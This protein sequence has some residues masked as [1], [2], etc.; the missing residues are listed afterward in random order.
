MQS[1]PLGGFH[2]RSD[3]GRRLAALLWDYSTDDNAVILALPRGGVPVAAEVS[4]TLSKP[5]DVLVVRRLGVPGNEEL[6]M[7]AITSGDVKLLD[8]ELIARQGIRQE[9]VDAAVERETA[10]VVRLLHAYREDRPP[11]DVRGKR[12]ILVDDGIASG[13]SM[14]A[15][16]A[17]LR[18]QQVGSVTVAVPVAQRDAARE[19]RAEADEVVVVLEPDEFHSVAH[20]Y[21]SFPQTG[22]EE[23]RRILAGGSPVAAV[24]V[25]G[26]AQ[27]MFNRSPIQMIRQLARPFIGA[28][29]DYDGLLE[30]IGDAS[31][32]VL[33]AAN[34]GTHEFYRIRADL[35][36][37]L[38]VEKGFNAVVTEADTV[39]SW[40]VNEYV[41]GEPG[42]PDSAAALEGYARFPAWVWCNAD[43]ANFIGWLRHHNAQA[44]AVDRQVG[45]YGL[46]LFGLRRSMA[47]AIEQLAHAGPDAVE[48]ARALFGCV[49][50]FGRDSRHFG[51]SPEV[52]DP[53]R[54]KLVGKL[55]KERLEVF[56]RLPG[57][58]GNPVDDELL[59]LVDG[60]PAETIASYY[61]DLLRGYASAWNLRDERMM[62]ML[63]NLAAALQSHTGSGKVVVWAHNA[64]AGDA[65]ATE[66]AWRGDVSL[67]QLVREGFPGQSRLI[68][69]TTYAGSVTASTGW[70]GPSQRLDLP[71]AAEGSFEKLFH[72]VG[73]AEFWLD[74]TRDHPAVAALKRPR[75]ERAV[76]VVHWGGGESETHAYEACIA[77]QFDALIHCDLTRAVE[78]LTPAANPEPLVRDGSPA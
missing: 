11:P 73:F 68:G 74:F 54:E 35:T 30:T 6:A 64:H 1:A 72:Q 16:I 51:A 66:M 48:K 78:P 13:S 43:F 8:E 31:V 56:R 2:D 4:T 53:M 29:A 34:Y 77:A 67:G 26:G 12:V 28:D 59:R 20:W 40:R 17:L 52:G 14:S 10:E 61:G 24:R 25:E 57:H 27:W 3:A 55:V 71:P 76:G 37:R 70:G 7:G 45:F 39:D 44:Y 47:K 36:K 19:L 23:V 49:D 22:D 69:M 32:V 65:R 21:G 18:R 38:V 58:G 75:M 15:A 46:D 5:V 42:I 9:E 50:R 62:G 60:I 63:V 33:G 41:R